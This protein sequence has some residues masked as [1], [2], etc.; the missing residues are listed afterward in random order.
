M[1]QTAREIRTL[2]DA[3]WAQHTALF[4]TNPHSLVNLTTALTSGIPGSQGQELQNQTANW[5]QGIFKCYQS[6]YAI[7]D[8]LENAAEGMSDADQ[9]V[10]QT[11]RKAAQEE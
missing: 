1:K 10:Q 2:L 8:A 9:S 7:A 3:Q 5:G 4:Q 6:L 11:F